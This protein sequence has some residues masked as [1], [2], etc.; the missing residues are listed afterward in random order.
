[1]CA[2]KTLLTAGTTTPHGVAARPT[3]AKLE[4]KKH[5]PK[6]RR[7]REKHRSTTKP[8]LLDWRGQSGAKGEGCHGQHC[9]AV[10][11]RWVAL[12]E[13]WSNDSNSTGDPAPQ[14]LGFLPNLVSQEGVPGRKAGRQEQRRIAPSQGGQHASHCLLVQT[15]VRHCNLTQTEPRPPS[16]EHATPPS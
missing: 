1:M 10:K 11:E 15:D 7:S 5:Q 13:S 8:A 16:E 6:I 4:T 9:A 12:G 14:F 2:V 3:A